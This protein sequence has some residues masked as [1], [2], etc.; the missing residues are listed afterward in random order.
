MH[1]RTGISHLENQLD[2]PPQNERPKEI[3]ND[4]N[5]THIQAPMAQDTSLHQNGYDMLPL[6]NGYGGYGNE[7][8][9]NGH[10]NGYVSQENHMQAPNAYQSLDQFNYPDPA[11]NHTYAAP[12]PSYLSASYTPQINSIA[13]SHYEQHPHSNEMASVASNLFSHG[14]PPANVYPQTSAYGM[15]PQSWDM[16][17]Q[18]LPNHFNIGP[19]DYNPANTLLQLS[20]HVQTSKDGMPPPDFVDAPT[21]QMWPWMM[22]QKG[23]Q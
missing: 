9:I 15:G 17:A 10:P 18:A 7:T 19:Q 23:S 13:A 20:N 5:G 14:L 1:I 2:P 11:N 6:H 16:Y 4:H 22:L 3:S 8:N 21:A 12:A